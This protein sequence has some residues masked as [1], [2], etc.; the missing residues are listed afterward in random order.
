MPSV[1]PNCAKE[2]RWYPLLSYL[3]IASRES[4]SSARTGPNHGICFFHK[5]EGLRS[6]KGEVPFLPTLANTLL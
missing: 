1:Y 6:L 5:G 3:E 2:S 4:V